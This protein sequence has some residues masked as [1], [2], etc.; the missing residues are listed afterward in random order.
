MQKNNRLLDNIEAEPRKY[1][2]IAGYEQA[3]LLPL[4]DALRQ[5]YAKILGLQKYVEEALQHCS[6]SNKYNMT[7][8][9]SAA[10][11]LYTMEWY[12]SEQTVYSMLNRTLRSEKRENIVEWFAYL[13]LFLNAL[14][15]LPEVKAVVWRGIKADLNSQY[16]QGR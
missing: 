2:P 13:K 10:I 16:E 14:N 4:K 11:F 6:K 8:E 3:P 7:R 9:E 12:P 1:L 5:L 15:K